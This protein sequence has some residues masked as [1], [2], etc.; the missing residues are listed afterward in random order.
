MG[1]FFFGLDAGLWPCV[2]VGVAL[3]WVGMIGFADE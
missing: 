1:L 3:C 2:L